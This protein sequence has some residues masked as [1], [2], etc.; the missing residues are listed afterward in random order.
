M[1]A[2]TAA[3]HEAPEEPA[4]DAAGTARPIEVDAS[5]EFAQLLAANRISLLVSTYDTGKVFLL[6]AHQRGMNVHFVA[7]DRAMG[8]AGDMQRIAIGTKSRICELYNMPALIPRVPAPVDETA[9][10]DGC[11]VTRQEHVTGDIAIHEMA[12]VGDELWFVNTRFSC[13]CTLNPPHSFEPRWRPP[14]VKGLSADDRC[15]LNGLAVADNRV[16]FVSAFAVTDEPEGWRPTRATSGIVMEVPSGKVVATGLSMPHSPRVYANHLWILN[17]GHGTID[18]VDRGTGRA[19]PFAQMSGF[20]RGLDF[21]GSLGFVGLSRVRESNVFGGLPLTE[22]IS[23][24][25]RFVGVQAVDLATGKLAGH[26]RFTS[27]VNEIF[28]VNVLRG[29]HYPTILERSDELV[30]TVYA[31]SPQALRELRPIEAETAPA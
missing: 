31:L 9:R 18:I 12:Y 4:P 15:H 20:T 3:P 29:L 25:D 17:S 27:G 5:P 7:F 11:Y 16:A 22:R 28:A 10:Y 21:H 24:N 13:L 2:D 8:I 6:R 19:Q 23:E 14:F 1:K 30:D 26:V